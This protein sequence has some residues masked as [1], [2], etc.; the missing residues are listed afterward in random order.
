M[1]NGRNGIHHDCFIFLSPIFI[2]TFLIVGHRRDD[3]I[4]R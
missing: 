1:V 4:S 2:V 3:F